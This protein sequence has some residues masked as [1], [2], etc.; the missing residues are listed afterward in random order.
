MP[1]AELKYSGDLNLDADAVLR[2]IEAVIQR[3]D[4]GAGVCK[5]RA[6]PTDRF[7]HTHCL[8]T[9]SM[10]TKPHRDEAWTAELL[11]ELK[12]ALGVLLEQRCYLSIGIEFTGSSYITAEHLP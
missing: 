4:A 1:H 12:A 7:N 9:V 5:G 2:E 6:Y 8:L 3:R 11:A 10:L